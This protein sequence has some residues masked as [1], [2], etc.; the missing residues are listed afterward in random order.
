L[1]IG[2]ILSSGIG[3]AHLQG[4]VISADRSTWRVRAKGALVAVTGIRFIDKL[5]SRLGFAFMLLGATVFMILWI[6]AT[7][8][9]ERMIPDLRW[10]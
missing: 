9:I 2:S 1:A 4:L 10:H 8:K 5:G 3:P 7:G 6:F